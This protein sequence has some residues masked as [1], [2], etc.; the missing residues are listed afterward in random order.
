MLKEC[1]L[2]IESNKYNIE[3]KEKKEK[4]ENIISETT[5]I[6]NR[7]KERLDKLVA[8]LGDDPDWFLVMRKRDNKHK[9][10]SGEKHDIFQ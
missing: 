1:R 7:G 5:L 8:T 10:P 9:E 2:Y 4:I 6:A 3:I